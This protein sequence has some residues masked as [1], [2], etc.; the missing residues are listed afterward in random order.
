MNP[1]KEYKSNLFWYFEAQTFEQYVRQ[2]VHICNEAKSS[3]SD[4]DALYLVGLEE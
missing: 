3:L 4:D 1:N 2:A